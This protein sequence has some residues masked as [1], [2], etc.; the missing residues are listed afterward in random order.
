MPAIWTLDNI[1]NKHDIYR[2]EDYMK[3]FCEFLW[4]HK[5]KIINFEKR[6]MIPLTNEHQEFHE[7][8]KLC[9]NWEKIEH[10]CIN[11]KNYLEVR[12]HCHYTSKYRRA[13][14]SNYSIT[15]EIPVVFHKASNYDYYILS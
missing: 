6:K 2:G 15:K 3:R 13:A 8:G 5:V 11:D 12:D 7:K 4:E 1:E 10:K 14:Y 9:Y